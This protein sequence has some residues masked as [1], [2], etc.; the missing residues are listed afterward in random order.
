MTATLKGLW[1]S[2]A[3]RPR[4]AG[5]RGYTDPARMRARPPPVEGRAAMPPVN[6]TTVAPPRACGRGIANLG[7]NVD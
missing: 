5:E 3:L 4:Q 2:P 1:A 7:D 6:E